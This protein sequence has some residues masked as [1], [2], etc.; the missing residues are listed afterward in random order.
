MFCTLA[1][2]LDS[3]GIREFQ[4]GFIFFFKPFL[5]HPIPISKHPGEPVS[6]VTLTVQNIYI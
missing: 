3:E 1:S 2:P 4:A 6:K 5:E